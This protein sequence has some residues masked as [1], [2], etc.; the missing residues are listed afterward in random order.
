MIQVPWPGTRPAISSIGVLGARVVRVLCLELTVGFSTDWFQVIDWFYSCIEMNYWI[1]NYWGKTVEVFATLSSF[2]CAFSEPCPWL[3]STHLCRYI[4]GGALC[5]VDQPFH[6]GH[7]QC[8]EQPSPDYTKYYPSGIHW[9]CKG[10]TKQGG[11]LYYVVSSWKPCLLPFLCW[12]VG[13][14]IVNA[15][16]KSGTYLSVLGFL[17]NYLL[18]E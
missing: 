3:V 18:N 12:S 9:P 8:F 1:G 17:S 5:L 13:A 15:P 14:S 10:N 7:L 6:F 4:Y 2:G 16:T 11:L